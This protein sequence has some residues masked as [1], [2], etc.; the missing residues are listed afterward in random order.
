[1]TLSEYCAHPHD[2]PFYEPSE[3]TTFHCDFC[4]DDVPE[5]DRVQEVDCPLC[6]D[7][8]GEYCKQKADANATK[9]FVGK[10][11]MD[12]YIDW[13]LNNLSGNE[14]LSAA[15]KAFNETETMQSKCDIMREFCLEEDGFFEF[16]REGNYE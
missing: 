1:M 9:S 15:K 13:W 11:E 12:F 4:G 14:L 3:P 16:V 2:L 10:H 6:S 7:C 5:Y 8:V